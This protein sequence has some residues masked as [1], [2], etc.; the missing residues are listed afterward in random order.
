MYRGFKDVSLADST[1]SR[2]K[3]DVSGF[4]ESAPGFERIDVRIILA[5]YCASADIEV[6]FAKYNTCIQHTVNSMQ[7][8]SLSDTTLKMTVCIEG[9]V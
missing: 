9:E 4:T 8:P 1:M 6:F 5:M 2:V 7:G 3:Y